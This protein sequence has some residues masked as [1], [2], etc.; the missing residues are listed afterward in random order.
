MQ[1]TNSTNIRFLVPKPRELFFDPYGARGM[2]ELDE[3]SS[4]LRIRR[5]ATN[6]ATTIV[7]VRKENGQFASCRNG[8]FGGSAGMIGCKHVYGRTYNAGASYHPFFGGY[9]TRQ[10]SAPRPPASPPT[11]AIGRNRTSSQAEFRDVNPLAALAVM[12]NLSA[13]GSLQL[14]G[15]GRDSD[16][17]SH[18]CLL[19][20]N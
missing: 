5:S 16:K 6:Q 8:V 10:S 19:N 7:S 13:G 11:R 20:S 9:G 18:P 15:V 2:A 17:K 4:I 14:A 1:E 3:T 12:P